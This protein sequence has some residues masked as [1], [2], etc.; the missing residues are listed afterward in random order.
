[1]KK[2]YKVEVDC[3]A[4]AAKIEDAIKKLDIV[5]DC[6]VNFMTQKMTLDTA[7]ENAASALKQA[8]K[9]GQSVDSD[10]EVLA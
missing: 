6:R 1:M 8:E 7:P 3:A 5:D 2:F 4:C 9:V 10:F